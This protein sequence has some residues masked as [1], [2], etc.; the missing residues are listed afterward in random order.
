MGTV[1]VAVGYTIALVGAAAFGAWL[2]RLADA[3]KPGY[4]RRLPASRATRGSR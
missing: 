4:M 1:L 3:R 2:R